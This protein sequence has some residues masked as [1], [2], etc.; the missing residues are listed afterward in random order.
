V[1]QQTGLSASVGAGTY[2]ARVRARSLEGTIT[3]PSNEVSFNVG[4]AGLVACTTPPTTPLG[5]SAS[6][7]GGLA[8]VN[9]GAASG[10]STY[11]VQ[12]G[13]AP[14]LS[15]VYYGNVGAATRVSAPVQAGFR[16]F[17]RVV[18]VN[19]CGQSAASSEVLVQ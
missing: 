13:S 2:F 19:A 16:A 18:A 12:A 7:A 5:V 9:W 4:G 14:G 11:L 1:G 6:V 17:V 15:D 10:A 3:A 8:T